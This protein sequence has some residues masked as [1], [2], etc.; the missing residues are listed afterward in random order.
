MKNLNSNL[1]LHF[2]K[3]HN[4]GEISCPDAGGRSDVPECPGNI[5]FTARINKNI[6]RDIKFKAS[7]CS[8]TIAAAS[9]LTTLAK[10]KDI[11][12]STLITGKEIEKYLG[13][14]PEEKKPVLNAAINTLQDLISDYI[15]KS[16]TENIYKKKN[17]KVAVAMSGGID[18]S[19]A[20]KILKDNG[21]EII[22]VTMKLLPYD[23]GW[24]DGAKTCCSR[25]DIETARKVSLKLNIPHVVINL[26]RPFE[27]NIINPFC[28]EYQHGRT[29]NPCVECNKYIKFGV[30]LEKIKT[31]GASFL[32]TGHYC[33][34]EKSPDSGLYEIKK[35]LDESKDQ[36]YVL[37]KLNQDQISQIKTPIG[38][39]SKDDVRKKTNSIFPFL[40]KKSESQDICFIPEDNFH[41]FLAS[42]LKNIKEGVI[43]NTNGK[44]I[45]THKGYPFYTIGQR[46]GLGISHSK[47]LYVKEIIPEKNIII[48]GE[49]KDIMKKSLKVKNTNFISGN[50]PG[51][52]FKATVKIRYNFKETSAEI[53][54]EDK[55]TAT[56]IF[57]KPQKA[58]T[59]GQSAV[60]YTGDTLIGGGVIIKS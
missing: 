50:L 30:L 33:R 8:Y 14:F 20:A 1:I 46:K 3:P 48:V 27:E 28:L 44:I 47:P 2:E 56:I 40:E 45:G 21:W 6:I 34:I 42:K 7:G 23:F 10:N 60:F 25:K 5:V 29:P 35:G 15:S 57:D 22:G 4:I 54:I 37:W 52:N 55:E 24:K 16:Q 38:M 49:E 36:S 32:A 53:K 18:S 39:F 51:N 13:K 9:Y 19:M 11:L 41:S 26:I 17:K 58:I 43:I 31:L 12:K 59:P